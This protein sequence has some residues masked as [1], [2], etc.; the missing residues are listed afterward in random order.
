MDEK[1]FKSKM[2][3]LID[4]LYQDTINNKIYWEKLDRMRYKHVVVA[5]NCTVNDAYTIT[6]KGKFIAVGILN[7]TDGLAK[8]SDSSNYFI[9]FVDSEFKAFDSYLDYEI[10]SPFDEPKLKFLF[11]AL[12]RQVYDID[13][14]LDELLQ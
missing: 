3:M 6:F 5:V 11:K 12:R 7:R 2:F 1:Q 13:G 9:S 8:D 4:M 10:L 14:F